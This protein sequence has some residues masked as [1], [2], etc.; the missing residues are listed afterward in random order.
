MELLQGL[1]LLKGYDAKPCFDVLRVAT[2]GYYK[3][4]YK[5]YYSQSPR[6]AETQGPKIGVGT[7][8]M[9]NNITLLFLVFLA[10]YTPKPCLT[11][12]AL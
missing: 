2:I 10:S 5:G 4:D 7:T 1:R 3:S 12:E 11:R 8:M 6:A 9:S